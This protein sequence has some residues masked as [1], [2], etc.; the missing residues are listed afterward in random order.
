MPVVPT[1]LI[2]N[3]QED[4]TCA[5]EPP[6]EGNIV[7]PSAL[8]IQRGDEEVNGNKKHLIESHFK[9]IITVYDQTAQ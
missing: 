5:K 8:G 4:N 1:E 9:S 7:L 2:C 6:L 3:P